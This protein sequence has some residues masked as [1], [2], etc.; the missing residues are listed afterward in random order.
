MNVDMLICQKV[1]LKGKIKTTRV[2]RLYY[3]SDVN[4]KISPGFK[5]N[6]IHR[7]VSVS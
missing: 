7:R 6:P 1:D 5:S 2:G 4:C 3:S